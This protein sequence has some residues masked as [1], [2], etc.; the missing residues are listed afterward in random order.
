MELLLR[1]QFGFKEVKV[2][3]DTPCPTNAIT[4][5]QPKRSN[6][7]TAIKKWLLKDVVLGDSLF[8]YFSGE[9]PPRRVEQADVRWAPC[10]HQLARCM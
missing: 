2:M 1:Q 8:F 5:L 3:R 7:I 9:G 4:W 6:I 10:A